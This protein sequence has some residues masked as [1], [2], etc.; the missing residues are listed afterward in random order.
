MFSGQELK[1][2]VWRK[3]LKRRLW[4]SA[5]YWLALHG[6]LSLISYTI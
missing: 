2:R 1:A 6:V 5:D 3:E 4:G